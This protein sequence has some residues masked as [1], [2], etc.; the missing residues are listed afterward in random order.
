MTDPA[1]HDAAPL[2]KLLAFRA[3][4]QRAAPP[5][6]QL[7]EH[8]FTAIQSGELAP[9]TRLPT[10]RALADATG[11]APNTVASAYRALDDA[12]AIEGRGRAGTFVSLAARGDAEAHRAALEFAERAHV[13]GITL[14]QA[15]ELVREAFRAQSGSSKT[16]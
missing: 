12:G 4:P 9:G 15:I 13:L 2:A 6:H 3:D 1:E 16:R 8:V 14:E 7:R 10:V 11:L 5:A